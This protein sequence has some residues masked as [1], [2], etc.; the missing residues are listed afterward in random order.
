M[1]QVTT[2]TCEQWRNDFIKAGQ[3]KLSGVNSD[4][5]KNIIYRVSPCNDEVVSNT[6]HYVI[7]QYH[8]NDKEN[9]L[10]K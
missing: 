5:I 2:Y 9:S 1:L 7:T 6:L 10:S 3:M 8:K 4:V